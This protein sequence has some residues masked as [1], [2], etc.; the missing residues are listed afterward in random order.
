MSKYSG[1][2]G[3]TRVIHGIQ[4]HSYAELFE[5]FLVILDA[6]VVVIK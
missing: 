4:T 5:Q 2:R 6:V 3:N 1:N